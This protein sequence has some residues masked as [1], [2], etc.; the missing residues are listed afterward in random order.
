MKSIDFVVILINMAHPN[1]L[2]CDL[3]S[4]FIRLRFSHKLTPDV[5]VDSAQTLQLAF[6]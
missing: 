4:A 5:T 1:K 3:K 6:L 2:N